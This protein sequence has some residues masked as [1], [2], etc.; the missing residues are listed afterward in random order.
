MG[1]REALSK[2]NRYADELEDYKLNLKDSKIFGALNFNPKAIMGTLAG[3]M[4]LKAA[5]LASGTAD[6]GTLLSTLHPVLGPAL[7]GSLLLRAGTQLFSGQK[8]LT[9]LKSQ[10]A[11]IQDSPSIL[12]IGDIIKTS[13][14]GMNSA[15]KS[16]MNNAMLMTAGGALVGGD[17]GH[18]LMN[19]SSIPYL[20]SGATSATTNPLRTATAV[21][22]GA[23]ALGL[24]GGEAG[25]SMSPMIAG[26]AYA[27]KILGGIVG[28]GTNLAGSLISSAGFGGAG[29]LVSDAGTGIMNA[30]SGLTNMALAD[31]TT[32]L[33]TGLLTNFIAS[34]MITKGMNFIK[35]Q[36]GGQKLLKSTSKMR[37]QMKPAHMLEKQYSRTIFLDTQVNML[38]QSG[39][40]KTGEW[41]MLS[42]LGAIEKSTSLIRFIAEYIQEHQESKKYSK[43]SNQN[44]I[45]GKFLQAGEEGGDLSGGYTKPDNLEDY[46]GW[47]KS[48]I[49][50]KQKINEKVFNFSKMLEIGSSFMDPLSYLIGG[51]QSPFAKWQKMKEDEN[52]T[53]TAKE[54][55]SKTGLN[56]SG[57]IAMETSGTELANLGETTEE[58]LLSV[59]VGM[60][61][62]QRMSLPKLIDI[63]NAM[64]VEQESSITGKFAEIQ[65]AIEA[66]RNTVETTNFEDII[67]TMTEIKFLPA[68]AGGLGLLIGGPIGAALA[69]GVTAASSP[70]ATYKE[71]QKEKAGLNKTFEDTLE[72]ESAA[73]G[74][75][76]LVL[77][78]LYGGSI[79]HGGGGGSGG[80]TNTDSLTLNS[81][82]SQITN[83]IRILKSKKEGAFVSFSDMS[84]DRLDKF[85]AQFNKI[86]DCVCD[87]DCGNCESGGTGKWLKEIYKIIRDKLVEIWNKPLG[88]SPILKLAVSGWD[89]IK[90]I[91]DKIKDKS[92]D[93]LD[94]FADGI[95]NMYTKISDFINQPLTNSP[96]YNISMD[97]FSKI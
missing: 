72:A 36:A 10:K 6:A 89:K 23:H 47:R 2:V 78:Q 95:E 77:S 66:K 45:Q 15:S 87:K 68:I 86:K 41:M 96:I 22:G 56:L 32:A 75:V 82:Y 35:E 59:T 51:E 7:M 20:A 28:G 39:Q 79:S 48:Y 29:K 5:T 17:M 37:P 85:T 16:L 31:P 65:E 54:I 64:G 46:T 55:S 38:G 12:N 44:L 21:A 13:S 11:A 91:W 14:I 8:S 97:A 76:D 18:A 9:D 50:F 88:E 67:Q 25:K 61:E 1:Y 90:D 34:P 81:I 58:K 24:I 73:G 42:Y 30:S 3:G 4:G 27:P 74:D 49:G 63:A 53:N 43:D 70:L 83:V 57:I 26:M 60:F 80:F 62:L 93:F 40:L 84:L 19:A 69:T 94:F 33:I 71:I 92:Q 52:F